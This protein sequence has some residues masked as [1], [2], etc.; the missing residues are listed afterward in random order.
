MH[1]AFS[2][3]ETVIH[4]DQ[5]TFEEIYSRHFRV[6][7]GIAIR[8]VRNSATAE[9]IVQ[10]IFVHFWRNC[11]KYDAAMGPLV[12]WLATLAR[13]KALDHVRSAAERQRRVEEGCDNVPASFKCSSPELAFNDLY[14]I[15][16]ILAVLATLRSEERGAIE[17]AYFEELT[18]REVAE[19]LNAPLGTV[20]S[21]IRTGLLRLRAGLRAPGYSV[22]FNAQD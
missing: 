1:A 13:N 22:G 15:N 14:W 8:I 16:R 18:H 17:L 5:E 7:Y 2:K 19:R 6:V 11:D 12:P 3:S 4:L 9:E 10:E 20:K 21:W